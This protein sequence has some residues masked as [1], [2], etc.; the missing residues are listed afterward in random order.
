MFSPKGLGYD[1]SLT[2]FSPDGRLYQVEYANEAVRRGTTSIGLKASD[3]LILVSLRGID[4]HS[5]LIEQ[6]SL[7]KIFLI[8]DHV[9]VTAAGLLS[10]ILFLVEHSRVYAQN[11]QLLY[12]EPASAKKIANYIAKVKQSYTQLGGYRPFGVATIV[13]GFNTYDS[14]GLY[15]TEPSGSYWSYKAVIV[16]EGSQELTE[17][18]EKQYKPTN[19]KTLLPIACNLLKSYFSSLAPRNVDIVTISQK[20]KLI[21]RFQIEEIQAL[22]IDT[23][24]K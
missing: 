13:A 8:N 15:Y 21:H 3:G 24:N 19:I 9:M 12:G 14:L 7:N 17:I 6:D 1:R 5:S 11:V 4:R 18:L 23:V 16:G 10:D 20:K 22:I 2:T